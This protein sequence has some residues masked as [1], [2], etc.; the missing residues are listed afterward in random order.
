[1]E[2]LVSFKQDTLFHPLFVRFKLPQQQTSGWKPAAT[3]VHKDANN[4]SMSSSL[5][6]SSNSTRKSVNTPT[7][8]AFSL[9]QRALSSSNDADCRRVGE[10][11]NLLLPDNSLRV[12]SD[13]ADD[14]N[15][16]YTAYFTD[17]ALESVANN[18]LM[19]TILVR[20]P[21][22]D[23]ADACA[24]VRPVQE[25][26]T[27]VQSSFYYPFAGAVAFVQPKT[28]PESTTVVAGEKVIWSSADAGVTD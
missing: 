10:R 11:L 2:Q 19:K 22:K 23:N 6:V 16:A 24:I 7:A 17:A 14:D 4:A 12:E 27:F 28:R 15:A 20:W 13:Q 18:V 1:M 9:H 25:R 8:P 26:T 3:Q 21:N 5:F